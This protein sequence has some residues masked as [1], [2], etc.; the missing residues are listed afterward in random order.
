MLVGLVLL[1]PRWADKREGEAKR[2]KRKKK[3]GRARPAIEIM[4][5]QRAFGCFTPNTRAMGE[6]KRAHPEQ[7]HNTACPMNGNVLCR[8]YSR[9]PWILARS[10][11]NWVGKVHVTTEN[12]ILAEGSGFVSSGAEK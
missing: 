11:G 2:Q 5:V 4:V 1:D 12:G 9:G 8:I 3:Y 6:K 7:R 10:H